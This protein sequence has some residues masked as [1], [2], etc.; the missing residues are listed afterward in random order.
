MPV[1]AAAV[2]ANGDSANLTALESGQHVQ[3]AVL[4]RADSPLWFLGDLVPV[5]PIKKVYSVGDLVAA[6][7]ALL[8][9]AQGMGSRG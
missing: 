7:G 4:M 1:S 9:V 8:M 6:L 3:K 2:I 5:P